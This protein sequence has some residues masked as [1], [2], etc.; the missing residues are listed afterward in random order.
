MSKPRL[1]KRGKR[2][3]RLR[4]RRAL[5]FKF[6]VTPQEME[7]IR[8]RAR[9]Y[10]NP[11]EFG[12]RTLLAGWALPAERVARVTAAFLPLQEVIERAA[13]VGFTAE[14]EAA[15]AALRGILKAVSER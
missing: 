13:S 14:A 3:Q 9:G 7:I 8:G 5:T 10:P 2:P 12:R 11:A 15:T 6:K 4:P 1:G